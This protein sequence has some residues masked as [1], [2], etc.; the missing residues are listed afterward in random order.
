MMA[1]KKAKRWF[2]DGRVQG[3][4]FR[5]FVAK[6][7]FELGV[8]GWTRNLADGRVEV[9]AAG[10]DRQLSDLA[11]ALHRGPAFADVRTVEESEAVPESG[12]GFHIR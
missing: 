2:V 7:A 5:A 9:Y 10:S 8:S 11:A 6:H 3:V 1:A 12:S 4:G